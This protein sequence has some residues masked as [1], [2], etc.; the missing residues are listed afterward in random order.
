VWCVCV[1]VGV[2]VCVPVCVSICVSVFDWACVFKCVCVCVCEGF[3]MD[4]PA[5]QLLL[6]WQRANG[7]SMR[8]TL[9]RIAV[10]CSV[11]QCVAV[12]CSVQQCVDGAFTCDTLQCDAA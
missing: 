10:C 7:A 1:C 3:H 2:C 12:Y 4:I 11:L 5:A 8:D 6:A 9:Q